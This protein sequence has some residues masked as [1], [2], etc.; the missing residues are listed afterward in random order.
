MNNLISKLN[1]FCNN[2]SGQIAIMFALLMVPMAVF[3]GAG[4]DW[5]QQINANTKLQS[6]L[7]SAALAVARRLSVDKDLTMDEMMAVAQKI[8]TANTKVSS[9]VKLDD[10]TLVF[11]DD[12]ITITQTG[13]VKTT[14]LKLVDISSL[15]LSV[16][17]QVNMKFGGVDLALAVDLSGS[18]GG[19]K[20]K[21]LKKATNILLD[22]LSN[23][24][25]SEMRVSFIPWTGSVN[26]NV[27]F[28]A[29][30]GVSNDKDDDKKKKKKKKKK[31]RHNKKKDEKTNTCV[32]P[33][34]SGKMAIVDIPLKHQ[35]ANPKDNYQACPTADLIPLTDLVEVVDGKTGKQK[36]K[37]IVQSWTAK[38]G[39]GSQN[40]MYWAWATLHE[41]FYGVF[42]TDT[43]A[44]PAAIK[45]Y[46]II[47][48]DGKNNKSVYNVKMLASCKA[49]KAEGIFIYAIVL[50]EN[51]SSV[52]NTFKQCASP[53]SEGRNYFIKTNTAAALTSSFKQIAAEI[54]SFY[55]SK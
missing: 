2:V 16:S 42:G 15:N 45:K 52:I 17:T 49:M 43:P 54:G 9:Y 6:T 31:K 55:L 18:M 27:Y 40:G 22:E 46:A 34:E 38:G 21:E 4:I 32:Q 1:K 7:D 51:S 10:F 37:S 8:I 12:L 48:T 33:R 36:L 29:V 19:T 24:A 25:V 3:I 5:S 13:A 20:L 41:A 35:P 53:S 30:T 28:E 26:L 11:A 14:F 44:D 50:M 39:T 23:A 47:M